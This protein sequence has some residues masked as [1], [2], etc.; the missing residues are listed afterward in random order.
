MVPNQGDQRALAEF[1]SG[2]ACALLLPV[3][4]V[5]GQPFLFLLS[6]PVHLLILVS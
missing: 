3:L 2:P 5:P 4:L 1:I 6:I